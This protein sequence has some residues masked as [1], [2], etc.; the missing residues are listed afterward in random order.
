MSFCVVIL[1]LKTEGRSD[2]FIKLYYFKKGKNATEAK[3]DLCSVW[4][5]CCDW[6]NVSKVIWEVSCERFHAGGCSTV[7][8]VEQNGEY[9]VQ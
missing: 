9:V 6:S 4:R 1:I 2:I 3:K 7:K 8:V 5:R